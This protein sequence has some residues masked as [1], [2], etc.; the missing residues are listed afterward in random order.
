MKINIGRPLAAGC[1]VGVTMFTDFYYVPKD[2]SHDYI[3]QQTK[4]KLADWPETPYR[5]TPASTG[6][7]IVGDTG[8]AST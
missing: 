4:Q 5:T 3:C 8:Y 6:Q 1:M 2:C 7:P